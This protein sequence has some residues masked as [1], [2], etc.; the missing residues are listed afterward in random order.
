MTLLPRPLLA[1][2]VACH[3]VEIQG[4]IAGANLLAVRHPPGH[5]VDRLVRQVLR[6]GRCVP[7]EEL[8]QARANLLVT[9]PSLLTIRIERAEQGVESL[10]GHRCLGQRGSPSSWKAAQ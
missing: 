6:E 10:A 2:D 7:G 4:G 3:T 8:D 1:K 5:A 9:P